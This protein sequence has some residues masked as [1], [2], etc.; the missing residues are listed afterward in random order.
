MPRAK[1][2]SKLANRLLVIKQ[3]SLFFGLIILTLGLSISLQSILAAWTGPLAGPP[4]CTAGNPGCDAPLNSGP[5][6]QLKTGALW[7]NSNGISPYGL[8]IEKGKVFINTTTPSTTAN[9]LVDGTIA[10]AA[11]VNDN[12]LTTKAWVLANAGGGGSSGVS[13]VNGVTWKGYTGLTYDGN[14]GGTKGMND[15]CNTNYAG[16]HACI[17]EEIMKL[18]ISYPW[19]YDAWVIDGV[20]VYGA[21]AYGYAPDQYKYL[22]TKDGHSYWTQVNYLNKNCN[23]WIDNGTAQTGGAYAGTDGYLL[24]TFCSSGYKYRI[25]CCS[26]VTDSFYYSVGGNPYYCKKTSISAGGLV[27][28]S[29]VN[30]GAPCGPGQ[31]CSS[32]TCP[33]IVATNPTYL[34]LSQ[35][36]N[37]KQFSVSWT[38]GTNNGGAGGCK[39][40]YLQSGSTWNDITSATS[41]NCDANASGAAYTLNADGWKANWGGTQIRIIRKLDNAL[42]GTFPQTIACAGTGGS[43]SPTPDKDEDCD[44]YWDNSVYGCQTCYTWVWSGIPCACGGGGCSPPCG[45]RAACCDGNRC[46]MVGA[47]CYDCGCGY[48]YY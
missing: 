41:V 46:E 45:S 7:L 4:T 44:G 23:G 16:S 30:D 1:F 3:A 37:L 48:T 10:A 20:E 36:T 40:Q 13:V 33:A 15:K 28:T 21:T 27:T 5:L 31:L 24:Q 29:S 17:Y 22:S 25:P 43:A 14:M 12:D 19:T 6:M 8:I 39:L 34:A 42:M 35:T 47:D 26:A 11:P 2:R 9:L 32:G 18:G 38:A